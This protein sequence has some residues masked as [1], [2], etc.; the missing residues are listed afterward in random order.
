MLRTFKNKKNRFRKTR[1]GGG[2]SSS[3]P[4]VSPYPPLPESPTNR[5]E[6]FTTNKNLERNINLQRKRLAPLGKRILNVRNKS[7]TSVI[8][9]K[10]KPK[11]NINEYGRP[12][13]FF[14]VTNKG[15]KPNSKS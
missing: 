7:W 12:M 2:I 4:K 6:L 11:P 13:S 14:P 10:E 8:L 3:K 15:F 9:G 5:P 1:R